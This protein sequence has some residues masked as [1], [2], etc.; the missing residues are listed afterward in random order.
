MK[1]PVREE[2]FD[3]ATGK[4]SMV[5]V[6]IVE[7][8]RQDIL[9]MLAMVTQ[10][11]TSVTINRKRK[12]R[13]IAGVEHWLAYGEFSSGEAMGTVSFS[14]TV[15]KDNPQFYD[16]NSVGFDM[17]TLGF[18]RVL[19]RSKEEMMLAFEREFKLFLNSMQAIPRR[20]PDIMCRIEELGKLARPDKEER[21]DTLTTEIY[22]MLGELTSKEMVQN[23]ANAT[24]R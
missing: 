4:V 6:D 12:E 17:N 16:V 8:V 21:A 18:H 22:H 1:Y 10:C 5:D 13:E 20:F 2:R 7:D 19:Y 9:S 15:K 24:R 23:Y 3:F 14:W 11:E